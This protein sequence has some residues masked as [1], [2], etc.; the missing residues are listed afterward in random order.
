MDIKLHLVE[1]ETTTVVQAVLDL[2]NDHLE[3]RGTATRNSTD[4]P[5]PIIVE[6][7]ATARALQDL[8]GQL[9]A[10]AAEKANTFSP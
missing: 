5:M 8:C 6:E 9:I 1:D 7:L 4:R 3:A 2:R 10:A